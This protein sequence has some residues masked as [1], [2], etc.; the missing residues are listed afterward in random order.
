[1]TLGRLSPLTARLLLRYVELLVTSLPST[2]VSWPQQCAPADCVEA[3]RTAA[4][5]TCRPLF[6]ASIDDLDVTKSPPPP[7]SAVASTLDSAAAAVDDC[8]EE[9]MFY[10]A[11]REN[12]PRASFPAAAILPTHPPISSRF[13][14]P[15]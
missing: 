1:M 5:A 13:E 7:V 15:G 14:L 8:V 3:Q 12:R 11:P 10:G 9:L 6:N 4:V 2:R